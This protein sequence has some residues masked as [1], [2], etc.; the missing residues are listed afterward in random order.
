MKSN[1]KYWVD[2]YNNGKIEINFETGEVFSY[3]SGK[4][5]HLL[6]CKH[7]SGYLQASSGDNR[8]NRNYILLHR[9]IWIISNGDIP[10]KME[11]NHIN[12]IKDDNRLI[13]LELTTKSGNGIHSHRI[14]GNKTGSVKGEQNKKSKLKESE[15]IEIRSRYKK[16]EITLKFLADEYGVSIPAIADIIK[17]RNWEWLK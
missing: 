6:N 12:G 13:N 3:L 9:L 14:L 2:L 4:N 16:G 17:Y 8:N 1:E 15:V 7:S 5:K 10:E 11:I